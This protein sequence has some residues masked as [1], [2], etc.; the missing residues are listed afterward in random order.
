MCPS[1]SDA[2][3]CPW[4]ASAPPP[5][6]DSEE[7]QRLQKV[8]DELQMQIGIAQSQVKRLRDNERLENMG[9]LLKCR[10]LVQAEIKELREQTRA[11]D[12][13]VGSQTRLC[14]SNLGQ[15]S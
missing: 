9:H 1:F 4:G 5:S 10:A 13:Q 14:G 11:L 8:R 3:L 15:M 12:R 2:E 7:I 6:L